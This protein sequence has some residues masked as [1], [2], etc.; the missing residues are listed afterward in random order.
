MAKRKNRHFFTGKKPEA[1]TPD[2]PPQ[3]NPMKNTLLEDMPEDSPEPDMESASSAEEPT[4][5]DIAPERG[6]EIASEPAAPESA[7]VLQEDIPVTSED[8]PVELKEIHDM[9]ETISTE[10]DQTPPVVDFVLTNPPA[11]E[12]DEEGDVQAEDA[13]S[14][15]SAEPGQTPPTVDFVLT[16]P[17]AQ[18]SDEEIDAQAEDAASADEE[19]AERESSTKNADFQWASL[20]GEDGENQVSAD[21]AEA[22]QEKDDATLAGASAKGKKEKPT[23]AHVQTGGPF[24]GKSLGPVLQAHAIMRDEEGNLMPT[25]ATLSSRLFTVLALVPILLPLVLYLAQV[26][27]TLDARSLWYSDEV[28]YASAYRAMVDTGN[29]LVL[30]LNG[31]V[32]PDKPPL[33][34]WFLYGIEEGVKALGQIIPLPF[35]MNDNLLFFGGVALS[36]LLCLMATHALASVV[37][38]VD[39]RTVLASDLILISCFFFAGMAHYLRMDILFTALITASHIFLFHAWVRDKAPMLMALGYLL[40][41]A[42]VLTKGPLGL[43]FPFLAGFFFLL[44]QGR[45]TRF[46]KLDAIFG[47]IVGLAVPGVWLALAWMNTGDAFLENILYKQVLA[48]ALDTWHHAEPW[49][50]YLITFPLIWLPWTLVFLFLP[51]GRFMGKGMRQGIK[52]SRTKDGAGIAY[53]WCAFLPGL[54]LLS[55]V[56]IKLPVYCLPLFPPL[57]I[58]VARA[59]LRMRP[60]ASACLQYSMAL[61]LVLLGGGLIL[62]HAIPGNYLPVPYIPNGVMVLGGIALFFGLALFFLIKSRRS[63]GTLLAVALFATAFAYPAWISTAPSLDR[64]LSPFNQAQMLKEYRT[65][66]YFTITYRVYG[67]TY[68]YYAGNVYDSPSWEDALAQAAKHPKTIFALRASFWDTLDKKPEGF[69]EVNRQRIAERNY[70]LVARPPLNAK[71]AEPAKP[72][73]PEVASPAAPSAPAPATPPP[74]PV[75]PAAPEA[76]VAVQAP[77]EPTPAP[78]EAVPPVAQPIPEVPT[79]TV[80]P[81]PVAPTPES[82]VVPVAPEAP[83]TVQA[84]AE[85]TPAPVEAVPPVAQPISEVPTETAPVAPSTPDAPAAAQTPVETDPAPA[86]Q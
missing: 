47:L 2:T 64:F 34:F 58:L 19:D 55:L 20:S 3:D 66:G 22:P 60:F 29:W 35:S 31:A 21:S 36:G 52:A 69:A 26:I 37:G 54:I 24:G 9:P 30:Q 70:V 6:E 14:T 83:A 32:Y 51:W 40:A 28:R 5:P 53:L 77:V 11:Q 56:S 74:P 15:V 7:P 25:P 86:A 81:A 57:A 45:I 10:P 39:R 80:P 12:H 72:V 63:E 46:F 43:A 17:P 85:P 4:P 8:I 18:E 23:K 59:V 84:P 48:R 68:T 41:G 71:V 13:A 65:A 79:E 44:W 50:H 82:P 78:V 1:G 33:F 38:R 27:F 42:A 16:N 49:Y 67:G 76:P 75:A 61:L 73:A 62:L